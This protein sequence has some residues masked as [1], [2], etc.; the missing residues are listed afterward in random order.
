MIFLKKKCKK[1]TLLFTDT[2]KI[3][4]LKTANLKILYL[5]KKLLDIL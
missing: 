4:I 5:I 3:Q 2:D 1:C